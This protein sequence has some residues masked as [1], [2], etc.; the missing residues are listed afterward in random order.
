[1]KEINTK[2]GPVIKKY[3]GIDYPLFIQK[4][5][6]QP[7]IIHFRSFLDVCKHDFTQPREGLHRQYENRNVGLC[8]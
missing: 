7:L 4:K 1:M 5:K 8:S 6:K 2:N 3:H